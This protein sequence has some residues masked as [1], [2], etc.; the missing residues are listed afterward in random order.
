VATFAYAREGWRG[1]G[2]GHGGVFVSGKAVGMKKGKAKP[3]KLGE[4]LFPHLRTAREGSG[5]RARSPFSSNRRGQ[6]DESPCG[7]WGGTPS[8]WRHVVGVRGRESV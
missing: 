6:G 4:A 7:V 5:E 1:S 2:R 3:W 8:D